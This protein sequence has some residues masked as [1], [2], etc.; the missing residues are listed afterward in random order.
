MATPVP[1]NAVIVSEQGFESSDPYDIIDSN[2]SFINALREEYLDFDDLP[3]D[4]LRSYY[5]DYYLAEV[6]NGGFSQFVYNSRWGEPV[7]TLVRDGLRV[8][9]ATRHLALFEKSAALVRRLGAKRLRTYLQSDY[10]GDNAERDELNAPNDEFF[11]ISKEEDLIALN[12]AWLRNLPHLV[13]MTVEEM[14]AEVKRRAAAIPD[15]AERIA[16]ARA[17][18]PRYMKLIRALCKHAGHELSR[19]TAGDPSHV[20]AGRQ[21]IAWHF[22]TDRGHHFMVEA[23]GKAIMF[24]GSSCRHICELD[25]PDDGT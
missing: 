17:N 8:M 5:V 19:V 24:E 10:W 7:L 25:A 4:A 21:T 13:V 11:E 9:G 15:R 22:L 6:N 12:A 20:Y 16:T 1:A 2:L 14:E 3:T 23:D 18:E